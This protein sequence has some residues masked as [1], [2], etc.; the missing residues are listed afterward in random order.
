MV[1]TDIPTAEVVAAVLSRMEMITKAIR[2]LSSAI[3]LG[4]V[5]VAIAI[6]VHALVVSKKPGGKSDVPD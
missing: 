3:L 6:A 4:L 1:G 2:L 5:A